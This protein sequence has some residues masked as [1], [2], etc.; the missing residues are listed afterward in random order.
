VVQRR[1]DQKAPDRPR[2]A[3]RQTKPDKGALIPEPQLTPAQA[4]T[5]T[6][7]PPPLPFLEPVFTLALD[8]HT[9]RCHLYL[10]HSLRL[11]ST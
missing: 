10:R 9:R 7:I 5:L 11:F 3:P 6:M 8:L 1:H 4:H 2:T